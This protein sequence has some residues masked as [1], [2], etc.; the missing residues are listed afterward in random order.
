MDE[1]TTKSNTK[2]ES[3]ST[4]KRKAKAIDF[5]S[6]QSKS[7]EDIVPGLVDRMDLKKLIFV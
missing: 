4:W 7:S 2:G 1:I 3:S 6:D 5:T